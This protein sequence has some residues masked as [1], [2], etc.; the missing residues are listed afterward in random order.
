MGALR[1]HHSQLGCHGLE[2]D[3]NSGE[4]ICPRITRMT[5]IDVPLL[6]GVGWQRER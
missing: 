5:R 2:Q 6:L 3:A 1:A 4:E